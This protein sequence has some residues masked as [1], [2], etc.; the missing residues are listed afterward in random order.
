M[1]IIST[2]TESSD[3]FY[4]PSL[5]DFFPPA[6][7][8]E[9]TFFEF[10]RVLFVRMVITAVLVGMFVLIGMRAKVIPGRG[11]ALFELILDF[12][13]VNVVEAVLGKQEGR[14]HEALIFFL[15]F[16]IFA[17]NVT[18]IIPGLNIASTGLIA[19]P[20]LLATLTFVWYLVAGI[21]QHGV[22]RYH[23]LSLFPPSVPK[24]L[25]VLMTPIDALQVFLIRP[26]SLT[27]RLAI[28]MLVGHLLLV[29][30]YSATQYFWVQA[31]DG[32]NLL[33]GLL[34]FIGILFMT[35]LELFV[36]GLQAFIFA[37]LTAV[38]INM[39]TAED[40]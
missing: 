10:N 23:S 5:N 3:G 14:R 7:F 4:S 38:Y 21:R 30:T 11:Q 40:H 32:V 12:L 8:G 6:L 25:L 1:T 34:T 27:V 22:G 19:L 26:A 28:N 18:G 29:L 16:T 33:F 13:R 36:A 9:G 39:A 37:M 15:F 20:L 24:P 31:A 17:F 2:A 35:V